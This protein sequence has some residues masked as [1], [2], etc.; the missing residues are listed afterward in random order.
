MKKV[1]YPHAKDLISRCRDELVASQE[2]RS[3]G[4]GE[5][6][7]IL[8]EQLGERAVIFTTRGSRTFVGPTRA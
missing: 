8:R 3:L 2:L 7:G 1:L 5:Q 4:Q 6:S